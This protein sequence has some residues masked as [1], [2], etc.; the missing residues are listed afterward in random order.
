MGY[1]GFS[2]LKYQLKNELNLEDKETDQIDM[3]ERNTQLI[4]ERQFQK[5]SDV[6][7][8][9]DE[10]ICY[11]QDQTRLVAEIG[12]ESFRVLD[13]K[14]Q[15]LKYQMEMKS[16]IEKSRNTLFFF[17]SFSGETADVIELAFKAKQFG[18]KVISL[19]N[20]SDNTLSK[21]SD[22]ALYCETESIVINNFKVFNKIPMLIILQSLFYY[23]MCKFTL[24]EHKTD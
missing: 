3:L 6:L 2:E 24:L 11:A 5:I 13:G 8:K 1:S 10:V 16:R 4:D 15:I 17:I 21:I 18:H 9:S 7:Y 12:L 20:L 14:F 22:Y 23:Y 19:T